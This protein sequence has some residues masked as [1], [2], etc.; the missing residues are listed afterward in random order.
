[1]KNVGAKGFTIVELLIVVVVIAILAAITIVSYNGITNQ[2]HDTAIKGD[3]TNLRKKL[4]LFNA[5]RG[6]LPPTNNDV[7]TAAEGFKASKGSYMVAPTTGHNLI[8][9]M[10]NGG[11][12]G[13]VVDYSIIAYSKSGKKFRITK[14]GNLQEYTTAWTDQTVACADSMTNYTNLSNYRG[15]ALDDTTGGPWRAWVGGN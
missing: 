6:Y 10:Y 1:M 12:P 13:V 4:E 15:Y 9:C 3:L 11:T 5:Q 7:N 2:T 14:D 8:Y